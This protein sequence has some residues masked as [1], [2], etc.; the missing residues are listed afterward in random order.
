[1]L[2]DWALALPPGLLGLLTLLPHV[3]IH[4]WLSASCQSNASEV[5]A[6]QEQHPQADIEGGT[7]PELPSTFWGLLMSTSLILFPGSNCK[8]SAFLPSALKFVGAI[9]TTKISA[10]QRCEGCGNFHSV[11]CSGVP[12]LRRKNI[13]SIT[14]SVAIARISSSAQS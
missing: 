5:Q 14:S 4:V 9:F 8:M 11:L 12:V 2:G 10:N 7:F 6:F 13:H 3:S 1:M